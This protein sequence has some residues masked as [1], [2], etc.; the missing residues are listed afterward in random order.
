MQSSVES[1]YNLSDSYEFNLN[2][3]NAG[4]FDHIITLG[5]LRYAK[6]VRLKKLDGWLVVCEMEFHNQGKQQEFFVVY[7]K[8]PDST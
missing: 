3:P 5:P 8:R 6:Y 4:R 1:S 7:I 2:K